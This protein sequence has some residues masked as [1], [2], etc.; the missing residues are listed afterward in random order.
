[1]CEEKGS[2]PYAMLPFIFQNINQA[3][4]ISQTNFDLS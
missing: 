2:I 1:M 3:I 4:I